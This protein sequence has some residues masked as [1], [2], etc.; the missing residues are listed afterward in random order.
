MKEG[1][2]TNIQIQSQPS[3]KEKESNKFLERVQRQEKPN[4]ENQKVKSS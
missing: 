4:N 3:L 1:Q 2:F